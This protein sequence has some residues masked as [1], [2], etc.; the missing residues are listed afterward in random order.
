MS[1]DSIDETI[2]HA[3]INIEPCP[4]CD[5]GRPNIIKVL[6]ERY[7]KGEMNWTIECKNMGCIFERSSPNRSLGALLQDWNIRP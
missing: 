5:A 1:V 2:V 7:I 6:D 3:L 4:F